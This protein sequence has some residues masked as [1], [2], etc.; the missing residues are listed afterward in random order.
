MSPYLRV[1]LSCILLAI[2]ALGACTAPRNVTAP[3][4]VAGPLPAGPR[5][6]RAARTATPQPPTDEEAIRQLVILEGQ[7]VVSQDIEGLMDLWADDATVIDAKNTP[8]DTT[9]DARWGGKDALRDR[10]VVLVFPGA[11]ATAGD[12]AVKIT[13]DGDKA[14]ATGTTTIGSEVSPGGDRWTFV[15]RDGRWWIESLTYNLESR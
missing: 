5:P 2:V 1:L 15:R 12:P 3:R 10:Y 6:T 7:G 4:S 8:A 13:V 14:T 9:D 11:P